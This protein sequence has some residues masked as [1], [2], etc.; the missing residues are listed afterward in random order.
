MRI[1]MSS[2]DETEN[3][4]EFYDKAAALLDQ[5][6]GQLDSLQF[7]RKWRAAFPKDDLDQYRYFIMRERSASVFFCVRASPA[8]NTALL[9]SADTRRCFVRPHHLYPQ[10]QVGKENS[11][12][13]FGWLTALPSDSKRSFLFSNTKLFLAASSLHYVLFLD[14]QTMC[15]SLHYH[16]FAS[17]HHL[18]HETHR[19]VYDTPIYVRAKILLTK[20]DLT[21]SFFYIRLLHKDF[22]YHSKKKAPS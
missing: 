12:A 1:R 6:G 18:T 4:E 19:H 17:I 13:D 20:T 10:F 22:L 2:G 15:S 11:R 16:F 9:P 7:G 8:C 3:M 21:Q 5:S 14:V